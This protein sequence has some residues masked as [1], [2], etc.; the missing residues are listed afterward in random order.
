MPGPAPTYPA[1]GILGSL[2]RFRRDPLGLLMAGFE[3]CGDVVRFRLLNR[4]LFLVAHPR[5]ARRVLQDHANQYDKG[6]R[7]FRVL[8]VFLRNGLL[9]SEGAHWLRQRRTVQPAF[10]RDRIAG[11]GD[12]MTSAA[13]DLVD[14][15][16]RSSSEPVNVTAD[17]MR[18]TLRIVG[19]TLLSTD[20]SQEADRV[21]QA[22]HIMLRGANEAISRVVP[23]PPWWPSRANRRQQAAMRTLDDVILHIIASRRTHSAVAAGTPAASSDDLLSM[24]MEARDEET[25]E[26]MSDAQLRDE[27]MTSFLAG[28]ETTAIALGWTWHL[29]G[30]H[31][32][33]RHR[34][35]QVVK[36]SMRLYPPAWVVSR[37]PMTDDV[38]GG[39]RI[40]AGSI[41]LTSPYVTHRHPDYWTDPARF[42]PDRFD[43]A[44]EVD[45]PPFAYF[46]FGGGPRQCIGNTFAMM[47][48]V[49]VVSI[50]A[51]RCRLDSTGPHDLGR[52]PAITLRAAT[53]ITMRVSRRA[54][55]LA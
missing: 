46:P 41:V 35:E 16:L 29:L 21:G 45:R 37:R 50:I 23:M 11:F 39:F 44:H 33:V 15:W 53:P 27:V 30:A 1:P 24:L 22:L 43:A 51:Q 49:L 9:T 38:V 26:G 4:S 12:T 19:E 10:H 13:G 32:A 40:P 47:E 6:T 2:P 17:M 36:E 18:L 48:L 34:V 31:P 55:A 28:H 3:T 20:V 42:D 5:D 52:S 7:G 8:R 54:A 14:E 25:G